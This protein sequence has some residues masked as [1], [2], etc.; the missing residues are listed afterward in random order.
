MIKSAKM[1]EIVVEGATFCD[2]WARSSECKWVW[3]DQ[4]LKLMIC[5]H[6]DRFRLYLNTIRVWTDFLKGD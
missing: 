5:D 6:D 2:L 3:G 4:I 1:Q